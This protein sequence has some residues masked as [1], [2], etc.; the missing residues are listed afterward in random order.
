MNREALGT[1]MNR[2]TEPPGSWQ[3][4]AAFIA[5][6]G[7]LALSC[8]G[9]SG[10]RIEGIL[11][12]ADG[13]PAA[14]VHLRLFAAD[15]VEFADTDVDG[16]YELSTSAVGEDGHL[17]ATINESEVEIG[18]LI[19]V[20]SKGDDVI[21]PTATEWMP[22]FQFVAEA[23]GAVSTSWSA[24]GGHN[25]SEY[26]VAL[27]QDSRFQWWQ[28]DHVLEPM[29]SF[30][31]A[32]LEDHSLSLAVTATTGFCGPLDFVLP[33]PGHDI[34]TAACVVQR[35]YSSTLPMAS[36]TPLSR[37]ATCSGRAGAMEEP[38]LTLG[39]QP[40][41]LT[42]GLAATGMFACPDWGCPQD[43]TIELAD[44]MSVGSVAVHGGSLDEELSYSVDV[45]TSVDGITY[46]Q[47][48][49]FSN[50]Y[51]YALVQLPKPV[52]AKFVRLHREQ[53]TF[54]SVGD[55]AIF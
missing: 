29:I 43:V 31:Q 51:L 42:D 48:G 49:T 39:Q 8:S 3:A 12:R 50:Y 7:T 1:R 52:Q 4:R 36:A 38:I 13:S 30:P 22:S 20:E 18:V 45:E 24:P 54:R 15:D 17:R 34:R 19:E 28:S 25:S 55:V 41:P 32:L 16:H 9:N 23:S 40:C 35:A 14:G 44:E 46:T 47:S 27:W 37:G 53:G 6:A 2:A 10:I 33:R 11:L 21:V 26:T 5:A